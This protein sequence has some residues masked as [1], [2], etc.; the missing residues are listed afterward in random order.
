VVVVLLRGGRQMFG[1]HAAEVA[2]RVYKDL[3]QPGPNED[4]ETK[5]ALGE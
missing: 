5:A 2:G 4:Q 3:Q 1:P